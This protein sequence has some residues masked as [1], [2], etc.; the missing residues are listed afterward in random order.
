MKKTSVALSLSL[1]LSSLSLTALAEDYPAPIQA[2]QEKGVTILDTFSAPSGLQGYAGLYQGRPYTL[3]LTADQQHVLIGSLVDAKGEDLSAAVIE[4]KISGPQSKLIWQNLQDK[5]HWVAEG[6][7]DAKRIVYVFTDPNC[8]FCKRFWNNA[9]P[10][11][12]SGKVQ[13]RHIPVGVLGESSEKKAAF[14]LAAKNPLQAL[15][16]NESGKKAAGEP[17][18]TAALQEKLQQNLEIMMMA[19]ATGTPAIF[20]KDNQ[21]QLQMYPGAAQGEQLVEIFGSKP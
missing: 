19:G 9:Q 8:P 4:E 13:L 20:Y 16:D 5:T 17:A 7:A 1:A 15:V 14:I 12:K 3:Y 11:V 6:K 10:W 21:D 2:M 18:I